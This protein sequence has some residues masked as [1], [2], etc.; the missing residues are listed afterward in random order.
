M[1][2]KEKE[3]CGRDA[4]RRGQRTERK[5]ARHIKYI[6][7]HARARA[8]T[9][10]HTHIYICRVYVCISG[11]KLPA[12]RDVTFQ[13]LRRIDYNAI[14]NGPRAAVA[15]CITSDNKRAKSRRRPLLRACQTRRLNSARIKHRSRRAGAFSLRVSEQRD[16]GE[17]TVMEN[18]NENCSLSR[19]AYHRGFYR[20]E[21][22]FSSLSVCPSV[23]GSGD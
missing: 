19:R 1:K 2:K 21:S 13:D 3:R 5:R 20:G 18:Q 15:R 4:A 10:T 6:Y 14:F 17:R 8:R 7:T 22:P 16:S 12:E 23:G 11:A 9:R